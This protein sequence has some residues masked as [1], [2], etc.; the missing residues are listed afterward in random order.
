MCKKNP[1]LFFLLIELTLVLHCTR[2]T[3]EW[4]YYFFTPTSA[5]PSLPTPQGHDCI[6]E[7]YWCLD[8]GKGSVISQSSLL[9]SALNSLSASKPRGEHSDLCWSWRVLCSPGCSPPSEVTPPSRKLQKLAQVSTDPGSWPSFPFS[10][11]ILERI[12]FSS[13]LY[14]LPLAQV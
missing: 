1:F 11:L 13:G 8:M 3:L 9:T 7:A 2:R 12:L 10:V 14:P 5:L 4:K 6:R